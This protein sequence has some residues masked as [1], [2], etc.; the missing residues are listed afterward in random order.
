MEYEEGLYTMPKSA[1]NLAC[2]LPAVFFSP[3][4]AHLYQ[5][6]RRRRRS[7]QENHHC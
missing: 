6:R 7:P 3:P 2:K 1:D 4:P 5:V